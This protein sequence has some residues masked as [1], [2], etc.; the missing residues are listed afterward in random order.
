MFTELTEEVRASWQLI[1]HP[2]ASLEPVPID[3]LFGS[4]ILVRREDLQRLVTEGFMVNDNIVC[5]AMDLLQHRNTR[6]QTHHAPVPNCLF[7]GSHFYTQM[8]YDAGN[9]YRYLP[10][11]PRG[12]D[13]FA[14]DRVYI[15]L[16]HPHLMHFTLACVD[17][18]NRCFFHFDSIG[19]NPA[20]QEQGVLD[21]L[22]CWLHDHARNRL[23]PTDPV[24]ARVADATSWPKR[25][26]AT[27]V[28]QQRWGSN[29]CGIMSSMFAALHSINQSLTFDNNLHVARKALA[30]AILSKRIE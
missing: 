20:L 25:Y 27:S 10:R 12:V 24:F 2:D 11:Q 19:D 21:H 22:A 30:H 5:S 8:Y 18:R 1:T 28:T 6:L 4:Q 9:T 7:L 16:H 26:T 15:M 3:G 14:F 13:V 17:M 29:D 23:S